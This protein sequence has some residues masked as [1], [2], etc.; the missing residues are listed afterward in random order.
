MSAPMTQYVL[1]V[2]RRP[3]LPVQSI[4]NI[5]SVHTVYTIHIRSHHHSELSRAVPVILRKD[6]VQEAVPYH[7]GDVIIV[8]RTRN[9]LTPP[10]PLGI[11]IATNVKDWIQFP[12]DLEGY[13]NAEG[14][15]VQI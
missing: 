10:P 1:R 9:D 6:R 15:I 3:N 7:L 2:M 13:H 5:Y 4:V 8:S 12:R 14:S 11:V